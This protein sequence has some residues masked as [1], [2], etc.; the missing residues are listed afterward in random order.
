MT[1]KSM[2]VWLH[3][4]VTVWQSQ[5]SA[6]R[7]SVGYWQH[8]YNECLCVERDSVEG[9]VAPSMLGNNTGA[10]CV[11]LETSD[12]TQWVTLLEPIMFTMY[13][14]FNRTH[15]YYRGLLRHCSH[16]QPPL[17]AEAYDVQPP[18]CVTAI[19]QHCTN[20]IKPIIIT[21]AYSITAH[22]SSHHCV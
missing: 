1:L 21:E 16:V 15:Y 17:C 8:C 6:Q 7:M 9:S 12:H 13:R 14:Q 22:I 4:S 11:L 18:L 20:L 19:N 10:L 2:T 5:F 3:D